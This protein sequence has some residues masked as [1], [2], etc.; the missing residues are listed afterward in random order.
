MKKYLLVIGICVALL[1]GYFVFTNYFYNQTQF[2]V[3]FL[4]IGQGDAALIK[5]SNGQ[6]MLVDCG[7]N[8][9]ILSALGKSLPFWDRTIDYVLATHPD[10]DHYGGCVDVARRYRVKHIITNGRGKPYDAYWREWNKVGQESGAEL[11]TLTGHQIWHFGSST[12]EFFSPD[13]TLDMVTKEDDN[14]NYSI[15]F[16]LTNENNK[17]FLFTGDMEAPLEKALLNKY[18]P[19][20]AFSAAQMATNSPLTPLLRKGENSNPP[21]SQKRGQGE[22]S[23]P[24]LSTCPL[25]SGILKVGHHGSNNSSSEEFLS[26]VRPKE[27]II[28]VGPNKFGHPS[29][30][31]IR[32]L[33][34][35]G[36]KIL[37]TDQIG[38]I[39]IK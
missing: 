9:I 19:E 4:N 30:R 18:C 10:L 24:I 8:S 33:E 31:V 14:N 29:L 25:R 16:K 28:S 22:I 34:R 38:D 13:D 39:L 6:K 20:F 23:L 21:L 26:V 17:N 3:T 32:H 36:A 7:P 2:S 12:L 35:V 5:F 37:R 11:I 15:V 27:A 1:A